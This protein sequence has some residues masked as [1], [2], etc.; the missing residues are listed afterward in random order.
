MFLF[1]SQRTF[2]NALTAM[3]LIEVHHF[4]PAQLPVSKS[5]S[6][7]VKPTSAYVSF[8]KPGISLVKI[9]L[10]QLSEKSGRKLFPFYRRACDW[11]PPI[12]NLRRQ[13][14]KIDPEGPKENLT[15]FLIPG[16][17]KKIK[18]VYISLFSFDRCLPKSW[19]LFLKSCRVENL[20]LLQNIQK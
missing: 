3:C 7:W 20:T 10:P 17:F 12:G 1:V 11:L 19:Y 9:L 15:N 14:N 16:T 2:V 5:V 8:I 13:L 4:P 6:S 18:K